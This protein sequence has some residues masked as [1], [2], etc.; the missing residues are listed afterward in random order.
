L[1]MYKV[2]LKDQSRNLIDDG[3]F[4]IQ[5]V[6]SRAQSLRVNPS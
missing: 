6:Q 5:I 2:E 1:E 3:V 4:K